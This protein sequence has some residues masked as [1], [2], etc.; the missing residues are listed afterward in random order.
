L[1]KKKDGSWR[2]CVDFRELNKNIV[3]HNCLMLIIDDLLDELRGASFFSKLD[4]RVDY[5]QIRV[6]EEDIHKIEF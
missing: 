6:V 1:V 2:V 5:H 4:L 3:K